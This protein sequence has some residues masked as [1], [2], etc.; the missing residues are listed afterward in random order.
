MTRSRGTGSDNPALPQESTLHQIFQYEPFIFE[1]SSTFE[2]LYRYEYNPGT[3]EVIEIVVYKRVRNGNPELGWL[4]CLSPKRKRGIPTEFDG[5]IY[6]VYALIS[7]GYLRGYM[8]SSGMFH[9]IDPMYFVFEKR[10]T[11][12]KE[13]K[14]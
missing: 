3:N 6:D 8:L 2:K 14:C 9:G 13:G 12:R 4:Q 5:K 10:S 1:V 11:K 7:E